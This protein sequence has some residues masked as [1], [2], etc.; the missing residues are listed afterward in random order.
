M[1]AQLLHDAIDWR[2]QRL[3][4]GPLGCLNYILTKP[5]SF[6]AGLDQIAMTRAL[7]Y[8]LGLLL[9]LYQSSDRRLRL[10]CA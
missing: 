7:E 5:C 9:G 6:P 2:C 3:Q 4:S 10:F 1:N 8:S